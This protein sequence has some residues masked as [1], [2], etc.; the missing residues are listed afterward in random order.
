MLLLADSSQCDERCQRNL[1]YMRQVRLAQGK[2]AGRIERVWL[3]TDDAMPR[4]EL[5]A[6]HPGLHVVRGTRESLEML[7]VPGGLRG[8]SHLRRRSARA[9]S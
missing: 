6:E 4:P 7:R 9:T 2:E 1:M 3:V 5:L 8:R